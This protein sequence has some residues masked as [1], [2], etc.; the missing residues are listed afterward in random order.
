MAT[1]V[2]VADG[3]QEH[4]RG[5]LKDHLARYE[6]RTSGGNADQAEACWVVALSTDGRQVRRDVQVDGGDW[7]ADDEGWEPEGVIWP[8]WPARPADEASSPA[9]ALSGVQKYWS[10]AGSRLRDSAKW[11]ATVLGAALAAVVGTSPLGALR[12]DH[13]H[14]PVA[15][16]VSGLTLLCLTLFLVVQVMRPQAVSFSDVQRARRR[17]GPFRTALGRWKDIVESH[18]DLYLPCG[19]KCLTRP[20][21]ASP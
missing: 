3:G 11:M 12:H 6:L 15:L 10:K 8:T 13:G 2:Q 5:E 1:A 20:A 16:L 17:I 14:G 18:E 21:C 7:Q 9:S 19:V 4:A